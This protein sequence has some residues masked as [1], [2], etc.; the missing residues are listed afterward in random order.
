MTKKKK[1]NENHA[2]E[3]RKKV[4]PKNSEFLRFHNRGIHV[5]EITFE[6]RWEIHILFFLQRCQTCSSRHKISRN[7]E[8]KYLFHLKHIFINL[9]YYMQAA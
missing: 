7:N 4:S 9:A 6:I 1:K 2:L 5:F 8:I 3:F